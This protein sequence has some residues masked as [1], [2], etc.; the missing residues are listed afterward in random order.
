MAPDAAH[1]PALASRI[2]R[3]LVILATIFILAILTI[4]GYTVVLIQNQ[5]SYARVI[6]IAGRQRMLNQM[7]MKD[8]LLASQ[9]G[10]ANS[11]VTERIWKGTLAALMNGGE[12]EL[13]GSR[14]TVALPG[15]ENELIRAKLD[16]QQR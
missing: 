8:V 6:N 14:T 12:A 4:L 3:Q 9:G 1:S 5:K 7:Y 11:S 10:R 15:T 2:T 13:L 16:E